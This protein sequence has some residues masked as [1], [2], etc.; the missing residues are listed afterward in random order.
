MKTKFV[1]LYV[2]ALSHNTVVTMG[3]KNDVCIL[4]KFIMNER[5]EIFIDELENRPD[6]LKEISLGGKPSIAI[7]YR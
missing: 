7:S 2:T 4:K 3:I 5:K 1:T 6:G